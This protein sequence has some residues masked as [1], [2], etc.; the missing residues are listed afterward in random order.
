MCICILWIPSKHNYL[1][2]WFWDML[3]LYDELLYM[4]IHVETVKLK[5][6]VLIFDYMKCIPDLLIGWLWKG[7]SINWNDQITDNNTTWI[8]LF[9]LRGLGHWYMEHSLSLLKNFISSRSHWIV[10][11]DKN[12]WPQFYPSVMRVYSLRFLVS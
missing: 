10:W 7:T 5:S 8:F 11:V 4:Q 2:K 9:Q 1:L 6:K 3:L 12:V